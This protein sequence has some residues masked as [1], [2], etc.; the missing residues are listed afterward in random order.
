MAGQ[1]MSK[2][3]GIS[4]VI[5]NNL[6]APTHFLC[7][8]L[9]NPRSRAKLQTLVETLR[10]DEAS[11]GI[12]RAAFRL[13]NSFHLQLCN[14]R[15]ET[16]DELHAASD[17]LRSLDISEIL[18]RDSSDLQA[19]CS[20]PVK[21]NPSNTRRQ[22]KIPPVKVTLEGIEAYPRVDKAVSVCSSFQHGLDRFIMLACSFS[23]MFASISVAGQPFQPRFTAE[24]ILGPNLLRTRYAKKW[25]TRVDTVGRARRI[26]SAAPLDIRGLFEKYKDTVWAEDLQIEKLSLCKEGRVKTFGGPNNS[27]LVD[28]EYEEVASIALPQ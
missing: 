6:R 17:L 1:L 8:P 16:L 22:V 20:G 13:P 11:I 26:Q 2:G 23:Q 18:G 27:I 15:I 3:L 21:S 10:S 28:E 4:S 9:C 14:L 19:A 12:P 25:D 7:L 24:K 5:T